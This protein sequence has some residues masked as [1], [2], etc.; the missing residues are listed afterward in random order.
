MLLDPVLRYAQWRGR[1]RF[2]W[3][4]PQHESS[5]TLWTFHGTA[6]VHQAVLALGLKRGDRVLLPSY[7]CG[8]E[9]EPVLRA[10]AEVGFYRIDAQ[11]RIDVDDLERSIEAKTRA[12]LVTHYFG[13][14][15]DLAPVKRLCDRHGLA[16]IE[17][18][19]H[20]LFSAD[21]ATP[22]GLA[23]TMAVYSLRKTLPLP[24]AGALVCHDDR[25]ALPAILKPPP[26][27]PTCIKA[28]E[29]GHKAWLLSPSG[30]SR[31][32]G[33]AAFF[34]AALAVRAAAGMSA[35]SRRFGAAQWDPDEESLDFPLEVLGWGID[36][37]VER[38]LASF[39]PAFVVAARRRNFAALLGAAHRFGDCRAL[40][41]TLPD[42]VCPLYFPVIAQDPKRLVARLRDGAVSALPWW[43]ELHAAV[44]WARFAEARHLKD[45]V[46]ALPVHQDLDERHMARIVGLLDHP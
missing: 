24:H 32:A 11:L 42:G 46:V 1:Q 36:A 37:R 4:L 35:A 14:P 23:G 43:G 10:G 5:R 26:R 31:R 18:C 16:L 21:G 3:A 13:F 45:H 28:M 30:A 9:V 29:R 17:D 7:N 33:Q 19:A 34:A 27:L 38:A 15:Q 6:A 40:F 41:S 2:S 22:L 12:V 8:H 39:D 44:P 20:A 25:L